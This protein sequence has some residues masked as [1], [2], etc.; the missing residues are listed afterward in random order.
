MAQSLGCC[1]TGP[2]LHREERGREAPLVSRCDD[3]EVAPETVTLTMPQLLDAMANYCRAGGCDVAAPY[4]SAYNE[5][6]LKASGGMF[7]PQR[8]TR[9]VDQVLRRSDH[10]CPMGYG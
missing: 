1:V 2:G 7:S 3:A 6:V 8:L 4:G 9:L 10:R 5:R